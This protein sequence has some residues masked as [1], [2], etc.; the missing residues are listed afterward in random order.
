MF[1]IAFMLVSNW[2]G[3]PEFAVESSPDQEVFQELIPQ[4]GE[5]HM[6]E[7]PYDDLDLGTYSPGEEMDGDP[8]MT[9]ALEEFHASMDRYSCNLNENRWSD[10]CRVET[11][12]DGN[13]VRYGN[14]FSNDA[15]PDATGTLTVEQN[16]HNLKKITLQIVFVDPVTGETL[17]TE[18]VAYRHADSGYEG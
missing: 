1:F 3:S 11:D 5:S 4:E 13:V 17:T 9:K 14:S 7:V 8:A 10:D 15:M 12:S 16:Q 2:M 18:R 6:L